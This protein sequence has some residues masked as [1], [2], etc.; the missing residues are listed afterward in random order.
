MSSAKKKFVFIGLILAVVLGA[1]LI[2]SGATHYSKDLIK[3]PPDGASPR[4][5]IF[6]RAQE[7]GL[8]ISSSCEYEIYSD[9]SMI[10]DEAMENE[11]PFDMVAS[12]GDEYISEVFN[13]YMGSPDW[14]EKE[15]TVEDYGP[16]RHGLIGSVK[17]LHFR[18]TPD[19]ST[20]TIVETQTV[21]GTTSISKKFDVGVELRF[22]F[23]RAGYKQA[24]RR[25]KVMSFPQEQTVEV[26][27]EK[28]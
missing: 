11:L 13:A 14:R 8:T 18:S 28:G 12:I 21:I 22:Q 7:F 2:Y 25:Y 26:T 17:T 23:D 19:T 16:I 1:Y 4:S 9:V 5:M 10:S 15:F 24:V 27:L 3:G 6:H 20:V